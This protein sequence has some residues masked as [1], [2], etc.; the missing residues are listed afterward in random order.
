MFPFENQNYKSSV[1]LFPIKVFSCSN[2]TNYFIQKI[3]NKNP[4]NLDVILLTA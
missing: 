1:S 2:L 3:K 4:Y